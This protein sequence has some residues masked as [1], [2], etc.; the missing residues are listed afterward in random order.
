MRL[1]P[2]AVSSPVAV[3]KGTLSFGRTLSMEKEKKT[4]HNGHSQTEA[5]DCLDTIDHFLYDRLKRGPSFSF[6]SGRKDKS[7]FSAMSET[8]KFFCISEL[9]IILV[10]VTD[11]AMIYYGPVISSDYF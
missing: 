3:I 7:H 2:N 8:R 5:L 11:F 9:L 10:D 4:N 6:F 1:F